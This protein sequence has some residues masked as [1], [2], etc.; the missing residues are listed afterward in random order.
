M[1]TRGQNGRVGGVVQ[2]MAVQDA[3]RLEIRRGEA[4]KGKAE[5]API[6]FVVVTNQLSVERCEI[7]LG[8]NGYRRAARCSAVGRARWLLKGR[9]ESVYDCER[10]EDAITVAMMGSNTSVM[11]ASQGCGEPSTGTPAAEF[12]WRGKYSGRKPTSSA[13]GVLEMRAVVE[14]V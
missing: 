7:A 4:R 13:G 6:R 2:L 11:T 5:E 3:T 1:R 10:G 12:C 14:R 8:V 9:P